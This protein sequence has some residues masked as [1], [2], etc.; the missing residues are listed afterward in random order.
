M[1]PPDIPDYVSPIVGYR[2]WN[3]HPNELRSLNGEDWL[4][5][6]ALTA[7]C[8][9]TDHVP[10]ADGC[11]CGV[12]AAKSF[13]HLQRITRSVEY[14]LH[15]EVY[16]WGKIVEH[17]LGYR[18]QFAYPKS[19]TL[20]LIDT[21]FE[22]SRL[23]SLIAY[24]ADIYTPL[25][26]LLCTKDGYT[27]AGIDWLAER[28]KPWCDRCKKWHGRILRMLDL[29]DNVM[30]LGRGIGSVERN[31][32]YSGGSS[33]S[34]YVRL[35]NNDLYIVPFDDMVW[36]CGNSRWEVDLSRCREA[37]VLPSSK[38]W[39]VI[40]GPSEQKS[41]D[42]AP[43]LPNPA[44]HRISTPP[45]RGDQSILR[46]PYKNQYKCP[47]GNRN[48]GENAIYCEPCNI[49]YEQFLWILNDDR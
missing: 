39:K 22:M 23:Q 11:S 10:P 43:L 41:S 13:Q 6:R 21:R 45:S 30:L 37:V 31:D 1:K 28:R 16:L 35:G 47:Y 14:C 19:L 25:N 49:R 9:K 40:C 24:G 7:K 12:Y 2:V 5:G 3:W 48:C 33:D 8:R 15:G 42:K 36:D 4:P 18:A 17:E 38:G 29:G 32:G 26:V 44:R 34:V 27:Q 46:A 20:P